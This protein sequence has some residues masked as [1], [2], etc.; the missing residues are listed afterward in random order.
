MR[1]YIA[2]VLLAGLLAMPGCN[3]NDA[4]SPRLCAEFIERPSTALH[5]CVKIGYSDAACFQSLD[6]A[7]LWVRDLNVMLCYE[8]NDAGSRGSLPQ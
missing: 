5:S 1:K 2:F 8:L 3:C 4:L 7:A 6:E